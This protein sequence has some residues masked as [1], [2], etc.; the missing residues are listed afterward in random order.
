MYAWKTKVSQASTWLISTLTT[1]A[2]NMSLL[3]YYFSNCIYSHVVYIK[4]HA[5]IIKKRINSAARSHECFFGSIGH[6]VLSMRENTVFLYSFLELRKCMLEQSQ[7]VVNSPTL[8]YI[9]HTTVEELTCLKYLVAVDC[10]IAI[11]ASNY[12]LLLFDGT[13]YDANN[14]LWKQTYYLLIIYLLQCTKNCGCFEN[15]L[16]KKSSVEFHCTYNKALW[17]DLLT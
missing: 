3:I 8:N 14:F 10:L 6:Y 5:L 2:I 16:R 11:Y 9:L 1:W 17:W 15:R 12:T 4:Y 7:E 13:H